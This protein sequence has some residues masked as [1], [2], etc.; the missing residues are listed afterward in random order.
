MMRHYFQSG[1]LLAGML[2][3]SGCAS[4]GKHVHQLAPQR[5][6]TLLD[7]LSGQVNGLKSRANG[8]DRQA[9]EA[10]LAMLSGRGVEVLMAQRAADV[11]VKVQVSPDN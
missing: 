5:P 11:Q 8:G 2:V 6:V 3:L 10:V 7:A 9:E 1:L 4:G